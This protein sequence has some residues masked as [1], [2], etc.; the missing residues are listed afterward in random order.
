MM[1]SHSLKMFC[2]FTDVL[3]DTDI[4][5]IIFFEYSRKLNFVG[6]FEHK[7]VLQV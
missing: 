2:L 5:I 7:L 6:V 1:T 3:F 4:L